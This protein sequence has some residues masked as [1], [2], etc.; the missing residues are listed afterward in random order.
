MDR[1]PRVA[2][3]GILVALTE[4]LGLDQAVPRERRG[5]L[6]VA[7]RIRGTGRGVRGR[8]GR[9]MHVDVDQLGAERT[10]ERFRQVARPEPEDD[11]AARVVD[12]EGLDVERASVEVG[13]GRIGV[14]ARAV[15]VEV[16]SATSRIRVPG[17]KSNRIVRLTCAV[18]P[19]GLTATTLR[20][21][22][23]PVTGMSMLNE[24]SAAAGAEATVVA[25][26]AS[27]FV[28]ET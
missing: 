20:T 15:V 8:G 22:V 7:R 2:S 1:V 4:A 3:V 19:V 14:V 12:L 9:V 10:P 11:I 6:E 23:P 16:R 27:V 17:T 24:P 18:P 25:E 13:G 26:F 5:D 21:L 28:A